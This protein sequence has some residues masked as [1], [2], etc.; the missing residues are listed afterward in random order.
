MRIRL[1]LSFVLVVLVSVFTVVLIARQGAATEVRAFMFRGGMAGQEGIV[2]NLEAYYREHGSW[3]G[4]EQILEPPGHRAGRGPSG[5]MGQRLRLA[6]PDGT[7]LVDTTGQTTGARLSRSELEAAFPLRSGLRT[8]GYLLPQGSMAFSQVEEQALV[9]R[10]TRAALT[11]GLIGGLLSLLLALLLAYR[12]MRP[13]RD[14][15]RAATGMGSGDLSQ[16]VRVTGGDELGKLGRAFNSMADSLERAESQRR[17]MTADI[18][19]ELRNPLAVQRANLEAIQD[20]IY[21]PTPESLEPILEQNRLLTR[22]VDDLRTLALADA[23]ELNLERRSLNLL[24]IARRAA[25]QFA[26]QAAG[27]DVEIQF[28]GD[29]IYATVDQERFEQILGNLLSNALRH[30][31][32]GGRILV[33]VK[34]GQPGSAVVQVRDSGPGIPS[35]ALPRVFERFYR[36]DRSRSRAEGGT[37]LGLA[38]ARRLAQAHGGELTASNHPEGGAV[39]TLTLPTNGRG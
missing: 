29:P 23:G 20:G 2:D 16:R 4:V 18:A 28:S 13:V 39:F 3:E 19:H 9:A 38:I 7:V 33:Q 14:L 8:V 12:L 34:H 36:A 5:M 35:D 24:P 10:L 15:T 31:P 6:A 21:P 25:E 27:R 26:S 32:A 11:A 1:L 22:L 17:A 30:T 37:G